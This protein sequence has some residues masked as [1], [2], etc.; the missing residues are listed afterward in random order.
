MVAANP[1]PLSTKSRYLQNDLNQSLLV[2][3]REFFSENPREIA[4][5]AFQENSDFM[6]NLEKTLDF[7]NL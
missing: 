4:A 1:T 6:S 2:N 3:E 7:T 5:K